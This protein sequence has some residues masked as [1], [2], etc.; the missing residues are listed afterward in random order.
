MSSTTTFFGYPIYHEKG[1]GFKLFGL[2]QELRGSY[3]P[4]NI[5][6]ENLENET[7]TLN[8][9]KCKVYIKIG[10]FLIAILLAIITL[11]VYLTGILKKYPDTNDCD[12][13]SELFDS[14][15]QFK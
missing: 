12:E 2:E 11:E 3:E 15:A 4:S 8:K 10:F 7:R 14:K 5:I 9:N 6:W 13:I 1:T